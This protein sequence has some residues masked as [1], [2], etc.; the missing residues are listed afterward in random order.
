MATSVNG[1]LTGRGADLI[2]MDD[3]QKPDE[4]LSDVRRSAAN[5]WYAST[6]M[7]RLNDKKNGQILGV[8]Q[9]LHSDDLTGSVIERER[10]DV[11]ALP[12]IA[13]QE[14]KYLIESPFGNS[15]FIRKAGEP[16]HPERDSLETLQGIRATV[17]DYVFESQYQQSPISLEG[18]LVKREFLQYYEPEEKPRASASCYRVWTR[19]TRMATPM[20]TASAPP[21]ASTVATS[22][23]ST[24]S[25]N[26]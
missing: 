5:E 22:I 26:G 13:Q 14:E 24:Y 7:S 6:L 25:A 18:N 4:A 23:C 19:P 11:L 21:G 2:I 17:G 12:V 1:V 15:Y 10:F 16:L 3:I 20:T 9:R 8:M